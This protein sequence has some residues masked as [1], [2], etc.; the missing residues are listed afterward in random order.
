M[1]KGSGPNSRVPELDRNRDEFWSKKKEDGQLATRWSQ[2]VASVEGAVGTGAL[3]VDVIGR[4]GS[5]GWRMARHGREVSRAAGRDPAAGR[6]G[7]DRQ[8]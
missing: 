1:T 4:A 3:V 5:R 7:G 6:G 8:I 2:R